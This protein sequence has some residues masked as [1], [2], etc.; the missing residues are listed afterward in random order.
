M[1][2]SVKVGE[3]KCKSILSRSKIYG[4]DYSVNPYIGCLHGCVYCYSRFMCRRAGY[5]PGD[6][7][8]FVN[9]KTNAL[10]TLKKNLKGSRR[11][12]VLLSSVTDPYQPV[13]EKYRLTRQLILELMNWKYPLTILTKSSLLSRDLDIFSGAPDLEIGFTLTVLDGETAK[14]FEPRA[15]PV[16][17]RIKT[18]RQASNKGIKTFIFFGPML[19][20]FSEH[21]FDE[22][23]DLASDIGVSRVI[24]DKLNIKSGNWKS[25][26]KALENNYPDKLN[27]YIDSLFK[28]NRYFHSLKRKILILSRQRRVPV[29]FCY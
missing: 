26:K 1:M 5:E 23:L 9:V 28:G 25:I 4:V 8:S 20:G 18:L 2:D 27:L 13:E 14:V 11:G 19:P 16:E 15:S 17:K 24:V 7:G 22:L 3:V 29:E 21:Y 10:E 12:I 6:W